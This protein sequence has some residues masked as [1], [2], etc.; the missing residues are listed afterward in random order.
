MRDSLFPEF[1]NGV[2]LTAG[3]KSGLLFAKFIV[4]VYEETVNEGMHAKGL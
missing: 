4:L 2:T 1:H 3:E